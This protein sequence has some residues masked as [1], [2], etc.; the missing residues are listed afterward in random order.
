M[1]SGKPTQPAPTGWGLRQ[2]GK[3]TLPGVPWSFGVSTSRLCVGSPFRSGE[4][5][6]PDPLLV[7]PG[8]EAYSCARGARCQSANGGRGIPVADSER[9][10]TRCFMARA[11]SI[12]AV[13][14]EFALLHK[15]TRGFAGGRRSVSR[16]GVRRKPPRAADPSFLRMTGGDGLTAR[17]VVRA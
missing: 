9:A 11:R 15:S 1:R 14:R 13:R 3:K 5:L 16:S 7:R 6:W 8:S 12:G 10:F 17:G 2:R 4:S